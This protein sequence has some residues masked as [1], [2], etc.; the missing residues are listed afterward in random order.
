MNPKGECDVY[1]NCTRLYNNIMTLRVV[2]NNLNPSLKVLGKRA[3]AL[4]YFQ[5]ASGE[6]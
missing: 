2:V 4:S 1:S 5:K 3:I 6:L